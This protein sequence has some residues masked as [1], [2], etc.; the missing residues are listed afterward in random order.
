MLL[1]IFDGLFAIVAYTH[2]AHYARRMATLQTKRN[3]INRKL[4]E[5][6]SELCTAIMVRLNRLKNCKVSQSH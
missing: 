1:E 4:A 6:Y 2:V 3:V 5:L